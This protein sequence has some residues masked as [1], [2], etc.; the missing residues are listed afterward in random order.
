MQRPV[1]HPNFFEEDAPAPV[2]RR[3]QL[4]SLLGG[5]L[6]R[7]CRLFFRLLTYDPLARISGFRVDEGTPFSRFIRGL[8][9][10]LAFVPVFIVAVACAI[11][12]IATH[13]RP[14]Q[15]QADPHSMGLYHEVVTLVSA[16]KV[17]LQAWLVPVLDASTV[18]A[19][20][21]KAIRKKYPAVVLVH[22]AS[23]RCQQ[24]LPLIKPLHDAGFVVLA[25]N[26]RGGQDN[27]Q[28]GETFGLNE[29]G[30]VKSAVELLRRKPF[31]DPDK[32]ALVGWGTGA[33][34]SLLAA[35]SDDR[36]AAVVAHAPLRDSDELLRSLV[37]PRNSWLT[38]LTPLCKW[39]FEL[40]YGVDIEDIDLANF[41]TLLA[42]GRVLLLESS[43]VRA[44]PSDPQAI[45]RTTRFL[46][47]LLTDYGHLA[48][49]S[50][51]P[52]AQTNF[53]RINQR[54]RQQRGALSG[55]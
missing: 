51:L 32:I 19:E 22:D 47:T 10:R 14:V 30:D 50:N 27:P 2:S 15:A 8:L 25:I 28:T 48:A 38:W 43:S 41:K 42:S 46:A 29:A 20:K 52:K 17:P 6:W 54:L 40:A 18:L 24:T 35:R 4:L 16:D 45:E 1:M 21:D 5:T 12:W 39:T 34:A 36:I 55:R 53:F 37:M 3:R 31:V 13:Q 23:Q 7:V 44:D 26:L 9:Y 49:A 11:V 33:N